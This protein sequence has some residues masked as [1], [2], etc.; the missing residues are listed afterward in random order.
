MGPSMGKSIFYRL[1]GLGKV[2]R[3]NRAKLEEEGIVLVEEGMPVSMT[4]I[5]FRGMGRL[6]LWRK[7]FFAGA[8]VLTKSRVYANSF[9][10]VIMDIQLADDHMKK[11][12][13]VLDE[14]R[15]RLEVTFDAADFIPAT[16]HIRLGFKCSQSRQFFDALQPFL[17][18][19]ADANA[20]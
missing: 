4:F 15:G 2:M 11:I 14:A 9:F 7:T 18:P 20:N 10:N 6:A 17:K 16:G 1:L 13:V 3:S 12:S 8:L 5:N 19:A